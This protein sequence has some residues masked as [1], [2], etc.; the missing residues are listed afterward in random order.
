MTRL[1]PVL[2]RS[3]LTAYEKLRVS[4]LVDEPVDYMDDAMFQDTA[5]ME[6]IFDEK[7]D[8]PSP[9][10]RWYAM[11]GQESEQRSDACS[12][13]LLTA[14][15]ERVLFLRF[16]YARRQAEMIRQ[17]IKPARPARDKSRRFLAW[18]DLSM[19]LRDQLAEYNLALVLAMTRRLPAKT[20]DI[21]EMIGEGNIALLRAIDKFRVDRGFKFSTYACR[22]ILKAFSRQGEKFT[23][24]RRYFP[25][26]FEPDFE[27]SNYPQ[28]KAAE[29]EMD[30]A[31]QVRYLFET[32]AADLTKLERDILHHRFFTAAADDGST[33]QPT[34]QE[35]G[36][37]VGLTKE[38]VR[39]I[40]NKALLRLRETLE[41]QYLDGS[42]L[43]PAGA[44]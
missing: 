34:L 41:S 12:A 15:Q 9:N 36:R 31:S 26:E 22:A 38:R 44:A 3:P 11:L 37:L 8:V 20:L 23:R 14:E 2:S 10:V 1:T 18:Y 42:A 5:A 21:N 32:N 13:P 16:N 19:Q 7:R 4:S 25:V 6:Q 43:S 27:K 33:K 24:F 17:T 40:Q 39:Q 29:H 35:V 30:A 28:E